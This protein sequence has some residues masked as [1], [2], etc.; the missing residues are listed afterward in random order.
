MLCLGAGSILGGDAGPEVRPAVRR[1]G[2]GLY[3]VGNATIDVE[4][5]AVRCPARVNMRRGGPIELL[6]CLA[7]GKVH[8]SVLVLDVAPLD[9]QIALLLLG[10]EPGRNPAVHYAEGEAHPTREGSPVRLKVKWAGP[11]KSEQPVDAG[12]LL[13]NVKTGGTAEGARWV[14]TGSR[15]VEGRFG[16]SIEGSLVV[17]Y[18]DPLALLELQAEEVNDDV[19]FNANEAAIPEV[20]T[21]AE[22]IIEAV[23]AD[24]A[25]TGGEKG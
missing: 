10:L 4:R 12:L 7:E 22:F 23:P 18:H 19:Y 5:R 11:G 17:A 21:E 9:L 14:F 8:E 2:P 25:G 1:L 13:R 3:A 20:G 6:A 16:A 24:A 15:W